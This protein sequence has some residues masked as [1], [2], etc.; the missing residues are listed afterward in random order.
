MFEIFLLNNK[1]E[2]FSKTFN[3]EFLFKKFLAKIKYS[4]NL[5]YLGYRRN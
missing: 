1:G 3:S 2:K 4:K 5:T